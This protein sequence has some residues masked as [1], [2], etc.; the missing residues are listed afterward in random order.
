MVSINRRACSASNTGFTLIELMIV[1]AVV[2]ILAAVA[3]PAYNES[4][5]KSKRAEGAAA[6]AGY[7]QRFE[8]CFTESFTY[9]GT[10]CPDADD[11]SNNPTENGYYKIKVERSATSY[12]L[13]ALSTFTDDRC[14]NLGLTHTGKKTETG[15]ED[16]AY[17]W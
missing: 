4:V 5:R 17:C 7:A 2:G 3:L 8:R 15:T 13:T 16:E 14:G 10:N 9:E 12:T 11:G 1:V 6:L